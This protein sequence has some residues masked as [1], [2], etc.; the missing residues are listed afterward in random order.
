M[1]N[2]LLCGIITFPPLRSEVQVQNFL[3]RV[4]N[5]TTHVAF[6]CKGETMHYSFVA[7]NWG[8]SKGFPLLQFHSKS[9]SISCRLTLKFEFCPE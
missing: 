9:N 5:D 1:C 4:S 3:S 8:I 6:T 2:Q 7:R